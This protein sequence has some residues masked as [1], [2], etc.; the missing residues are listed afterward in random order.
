MYT[1]KPIIFPQYFLW[2]YPPVL[3]IFWSLSTTPIQVA[4]CVILPVAV[5]V[6]HVGG[7]IWVGNK[8][9]LGDKTANFHSTAF[10]VLKQ[11]VSKLVPVPSKFRLVAIFLFP[12]LKF[13]NTLASLIVNESNLKKKHQTDFGIREPCQ[14]LGTWH[15]A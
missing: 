12:V 14:S 13:V 9:H 2:W 8:K 4:R 15:H 1:T 5:L 3:S 11:C 6:V 7:I 10:P